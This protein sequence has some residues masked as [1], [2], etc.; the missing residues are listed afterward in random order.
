VDGIEIRYAGVLLGRATQ[1]RDQ[2]HQGLFVG[3]AEPLPVGTP[4][5]LKGA[6]GEQRGRVTEVVESADPTVAG[7]RVSTGAAAAQTAP[8]AAVAQTAPSS[9]AAVQTAPAAAPVAVSAVVEAH[10][11]EGEQA[12]GPHDGNAS[13]PHDGGRRKRRRR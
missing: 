3:F 7:M 6:D 2:G 9:A 8:A 4:I 11:P 13:G 1:V 5:A 10:H 12:S